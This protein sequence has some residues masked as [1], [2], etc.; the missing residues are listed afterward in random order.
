MRW[1][2][3]SHWLNGARPGLGPSGSGVVE[4]LG[5]DRRLQIQGGSLSSALGPR[6]T[7]QDCHRPVH[8][9]HVTIIWLAFSLQPHKEGGKD[10]LSLYPFEVKT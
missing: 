1:R 3:I 8:T 6:E 10:L 5:R 2:F 4:P 7:Q 9:P